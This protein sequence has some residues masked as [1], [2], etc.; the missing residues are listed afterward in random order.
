MFFFFFHVEGGGIAFN[1]EFECM[2]ILFWEAIDSIP[3]QGGRTHNCPPML[4]LLIV[5]CNKLCDYSTKHQSK[6]QNLKNASWRDFES[7]FSV[8]R[9]TKY[10]LFLVFV[11]VKS[12]RNCFCVTQKLVTQCMRYYERIP[13]REYRMLPLGFYEREKNV[14]EWW[15][16]TKENEMSSLFSISFQRNN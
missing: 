16:E 13:S 9:I 8:I 12:S 11:F 4:S 15:W 1:F 5:L 7:V 3:E 14:F 2:Y 6:I 10:L